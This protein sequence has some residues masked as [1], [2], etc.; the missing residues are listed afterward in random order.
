MII[1][2]LSHLDH[3]LTADHVAHLLALFG[4]RSAFFIETI[5][6]PANLAAVPCNLHGPV[7]GEAPVLD[8]EATFVV[9]GDR[10]GASRMCSRPPTMT[11][12][13]TVIAGPI[14]ADRCVLYTAYGGPLAPREPWDPGL[15]ATGAEAS[16]VF[17]AEHALGKG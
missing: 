2:A 3:S 8:S 11:R 10:K 17:W 6:L 15:D 14:G 9:R 13:L 4:E 12:T 5:V 1:S 16:R 7:V